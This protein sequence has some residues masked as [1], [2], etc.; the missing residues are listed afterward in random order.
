MHSF[1]YNK[2]MFIILHGHTVKFISDI[3]LVY[4]YSTIKMMHGP[5]NIR[6]SKRVYNIRDVT[7]FESRGLNE[8]DV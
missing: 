5:I 1:G 8:W 4:L 6:V 2:Y 3:K 7:V